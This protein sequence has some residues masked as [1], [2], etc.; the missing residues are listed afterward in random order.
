M[1]Y[2]IGRIRVRA[3][4]R[5]EFLDRVQ[6]FVEAARAIPGCV[7]FHETADSQDEDLVLVAECFTDA[8]AHAEH[9]RSAHYEAFTPIFAE[10]LISGE[11]DDLD[12][13]SLEPTHVDFSH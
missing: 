13:V 5:Q 8:E 1:R 7:Y 4:K 3:G 2:V 11:F 12:A 10:Y 6:P 9:L